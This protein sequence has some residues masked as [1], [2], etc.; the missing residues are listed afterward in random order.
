MS[1]SFELTKSLL[2][3]LK[4]S[5]TC[6]LDKERRSMRNTPYP[7]YTIGH[8]EHGVFDLDKATGLIQGITRLRDRKEVKASDLQNFDHLRQG[9]V[10]TFADGG[11][12]EVVDFGGYQ[13]RGGFVSSLHTQHIDLEPGAK[14]TGPAAWRA[15]VLEAVEPALEAAGTESGL[16]TAVMVAVVVALFAGSAAFSLAAALISVAMTA[17]L[18][19]LFFVFDQYDKYRIRTIERMG[20]AYILAPQTRTW[21]GAPTA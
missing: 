10:R 11:Q 12:I 2:Q 7:R 17:F 15:V 5:G 21:A 20:S 3:V 8:R 13:S 1:P 19:L 6:S 18:A 4:L 16:G 9:E 14:L